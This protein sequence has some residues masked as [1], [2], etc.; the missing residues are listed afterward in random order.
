MPRLLL[1]GIVERLLPA[2]RAWYQPLVRHFAFIEEQQRASQT[3]PAVANVLR[4][5]DYFAARGDSEAVEI[6]N[7][8]LQQENSEQAVAFS[9][10]KLLPARL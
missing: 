8:G 2:D 6:L 9:T 3:S 1:R 7:E 10:H 4:L 5:R